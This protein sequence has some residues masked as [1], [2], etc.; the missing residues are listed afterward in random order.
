[1][2]GANSTYIIAAARPCM[3]SQ[4]P[5]NSTHYMPILLS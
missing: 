2:L 5:L 4:T 3:V 1:M